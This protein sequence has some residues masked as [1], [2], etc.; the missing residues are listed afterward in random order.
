MTTAPGVVP[1]SVLYKVSD[2]KISK[3]DRVRFLI[4]HSA[5][6]PRTTKRTERMS[7]GQRDA[8]F[9]EM[10]MSTK[11]LS[12]ERTYSNIDI[13]NQAIPART[14]PDKRSTFEGFFWQFSLFFILEPTASTVSS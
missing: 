10:S 13:A 11:E 1:R 7:L 14:M 8:G 9:S 6:A 3:L 5:P 2:S 12:A 4:N